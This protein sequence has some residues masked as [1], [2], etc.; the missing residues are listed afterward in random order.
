MA[1]YD[2]T[3]ESPPRF[4]RRIGDHVLQGSN[5]TLIVLGTDRP[6]NQDSGKKGKDAGTIHL[7]SGRKSED[8]SFADD[9]S[10]IYISA[11]TDIDKNLSLQKI[12]SETGPAIALKSDHV[13]IVGRKTSRVFVGENDYFVLKSGEATIESSTIKLGK[14]AKEP[15]IL[16]TTYRQNEIQLNNKLSGFF[17]Q[18]QALLIAAEASIN[19]NTFGVTSGGNLAQAAAIVGQCSQALKDFEGNSGRYLSKVSKTV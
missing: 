19:A 18:I 14:D 12:S 10:F 2:L 7:V 4:I 15:L 16:G 11:G 13:R 6:G 17:D 9:A 8:P 3:K 5:N 1:S